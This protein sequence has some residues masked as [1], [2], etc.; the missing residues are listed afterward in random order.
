M[1]PLIS[2]I[3]LFFFRMLWA[4]LRRSMGRFLGRFQ[5]VQSSKTKISLKRFSLMKFVLQ[6][7]NASCVEPHVKTSGWNHSLSVSPGG[8]C[9]LFKWSTSLSHPSLTHHAAVTRQPCAPLPFLLLHAT[10][11][12]DVHLMQRE[13]RRNE[14][15]I[16]LLVSDRRLLVVQTLQ[17]SVNS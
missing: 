12:S 7:K 13:R 4:G 17:E 6:Q 16:S 9:F 14:T 1:L 8:F 11:C 15:C 3:V 5:L 10:L 2:G